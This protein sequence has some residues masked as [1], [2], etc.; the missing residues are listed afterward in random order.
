MVLGAAVG[1]AVLGRQ[2]GRRA[3]LWGAAFGALPDLDVLV[4]PF[5]DP[6]AQLAVHRG[7]THS[8]VF[9]GLGGLLFGRLL[10]RHYPQASQSRWGLLVGLALL[11]HSMLDVF[12]VY[13]TQILNP[14]SDWPAAIGSIFIIDP[15]YTLPLLGG[16]GAALLYSQNARRRRWLNG[17]G[18]GLSTAYLL[19]GLG[20][21]QIARSSFQD[22]LQQQNGPRQQLLVTPTPF[23]SVL[24]MGVAAD[25]SQIWVGLRSL[26]DGPGPIR[27]HKK[28]KNPHL[29]QSFLGQRPLERLLWFSRGYYT[30]ER[31]G[32]QLYFNDL[33]FGSADAWLGE[34]G[35]YIF[36][37]QLLRDPL[38]PRRLRGFRQIQPPFDLDRVDWSALW[39]RVMGIPPAE[40]P[41]GFVKK[42]P[43]KGE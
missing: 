14:F 36:R 34:G 33:R 27:F 23:N 25:S 30:V 29:L 1:E 31:Q 18:L 43:W 11:T 7:F 22:Q 38:D 19:L 39:N 37:F 41:R 16:L 42:N 17:L 13:G 10:A 32:G 24:W 15:L 40:S 4:N 9:A 21:Q 3:P 26:L 20:C 2:I 12:T 6:V 5:I 8:L 28:D 35:D